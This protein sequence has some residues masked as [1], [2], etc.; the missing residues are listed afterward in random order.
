MSQEGPRL[1]PGAS[2]KKDIVL[3]ILSQKKHSCPKT[4]SKWDVL[5]KEIAS[6][7]EY[8]KITYNS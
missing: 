3:Y 5:S 7:H 4:N 8:D 1:E 2:I 6:T